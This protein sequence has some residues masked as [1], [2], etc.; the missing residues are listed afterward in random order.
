MLDI[1]GL[2]LDDPAVYELLSNGDTVGVFQLKVT[3]Y[4]GFFVNL[5][6][7]VLKR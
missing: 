2:P 3:V 1:D 4:A 6:R 5:N 7:T